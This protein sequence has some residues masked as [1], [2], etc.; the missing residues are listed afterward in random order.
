MGR[1]LSSRR[2]KT[3]IIKRQRSLSSKMSKMRQKFHEA[4]DNNSDNENQENNEKRPIDWGSD[5]EE[6]WVTEN[7]EECIAEAEVFTK[8]KTAAKFTTAAL[9]MAMDMCRKP[10]GSTKTISKSVDEF[11]GSKLGTVYSKTVDEN[12]NPMAKSLAFPTTIN[13][14]NVVCHYTYANDDIVLKDGDVVKIHLGCQIDGYPAIAGD[15]L[16][17]G[18]LDGV[19]PT[20]INVVNATKVAIA[21]AVRTLH[22]TEQNG[23]VSDVIQNV[24]DYFNVEPVEGVLSHRIK[25]FIIDGQKAIITRRILDVEPIQDVEPMDIDVNHVYNLDIVFSNS[26][27]RLKPSDTHATT[28]YRRTEVQAPI[29]MKTARHALMEIRK[30]FYT[31]PFV[32][33]DVFPED[34]ARSSFGTQLLA[35]SAVVDPFLVMES[36][37]GAVTARCSCTVAVTNRTIDVLCGPGSFFAPNAQ[38]PQELRAILTRPLNHN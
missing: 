21:A 5:E 4:T 33:N 34:P 8:Y 24:A 18:C 28:M 23:D 17:V 13:V 25:R 15:T 29:R 36:K 1:G 11:L 22:P 37:G 38:W 3:P 14:N 7:E 6:D 16:I 9:E 10:G 30:R 19:D 32:V 20:S 31:F 2:S 35:K 27:F 26:D 12:G